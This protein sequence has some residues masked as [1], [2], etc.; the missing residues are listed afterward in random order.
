[1]SKAAL[2]SSRKE[3]VQHKTFHRYTVRAKRG[4]AQGLRDA[5]NRSHAPKSAGAS[6]RRYNETALLKA[7][8]PTPPLHLDLDPHVYR[9][10]S[11]AGGWTPSLKFLD[12]K[13]HGPHSANLPTL[14]KEP[15]SYLLL[16]VMSEINFYGLL[17]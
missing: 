9:M 1:M 12:S 7:R 14:S 3:V 13:P 6:L 15:N 17:L 10:V 11:W 5:Q 2:R 16:A 8:H 4:T